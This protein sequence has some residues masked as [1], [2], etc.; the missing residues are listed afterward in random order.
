METPESV[1][2]DKGV[3]DPLI[4]SDKRHAPFVFWSLPAPFSSTT[5]GTTYSSPWHFSCFNSFSREL[6]P[7]DSANRI[8]GADHGDHLFIVRS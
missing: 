7:A 1:G 2:G 5:H 8:L 6:F 4:K 3:W